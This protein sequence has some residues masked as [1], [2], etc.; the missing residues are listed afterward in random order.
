MWAKRTDT[1]TP[2]DNLEKL[3]ELEKECDFPNFST[4]VLLSKF[5]NHRKKTTGQTV[6][7]KRIGCAEK[8][9]KIYSKIHMTKRKKE[10]GTGSTNI[11]PLS[12]HHIF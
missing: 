12:P 11:K 1:E 5:I 3:I 2:E 6:E 9:L 7:R 10:Y 8:K 4:E